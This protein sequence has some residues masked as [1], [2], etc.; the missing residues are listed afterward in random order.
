MGLR[1]SSVPVPSA[2]GVVLAGHADGTF[3]WDTQLGS[4]T[5]PVTD[6]SAARPSL[7]VV[8]WKTATK[9][10]NIS[11]A[12]VWI[13]TASRGAT[14]WGGWRP[15]DNGLIGAT[16]DIG[17]GTT[18][19]IAMV[20]QRVMTGLIHIE[21]PETI[22]N[23]VFSLTT[24]GVGTAGALFAVYSLAGALLG[25][26]DIT[27][28]LN[29][30]TLGALTTGAL[31]PA[32]AGSLNVTSNVIAAIYAQTIGTTAPSIQQSVN[33]ADAEALNFG[34]ASPAY[35]GARISGQ[36]TLPTNLP[37]LTKETRMP[38]LAVK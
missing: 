37:A 17:Q 31:T 28:L 27:A 4:P 13:D 15:S 30:S 8:Y 12:D 23:G 34:Q 14:M 33:S 19:G 11:A 2:D 16:F 9:P 18:S 6:A 29:G 36:A 24:A 32:S 35:R 22:T 10:A 21:Q 26:V 25:S 7:P 5:N 3:G 38:W 1:I 20:A